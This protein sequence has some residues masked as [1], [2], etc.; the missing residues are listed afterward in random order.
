MSSM[1]FEAQRDLNSR[2]IY[3]RIRERGTQHPELLS[4]EKDQSENQRDY[5]YKVI[6]LILNE[7]DPD[8]FHSL[9]KEDLREDL[10]EQCLYNI[11]RCE[12]DLR[13]QFDYA[14][15]EAIE[16]AQVIAAQT[17]F[18]VEG[19]A[20]LS[21]GAHSLPPIPDDFLEYS[22]EEKMEYQRKARERRYLRVVVIMFL[23]LFDKEMDD[24]YKYQEKT[25]DS[26]SPETN[27]VREQIS[28]AANALPKDPTY[29]RDKLRFLLNLVWDENANSQKTKPLNPTHQEE[30]LVEIMEGN[31]LEG[32]SILVQWIRMVNTVE[33]IDKK[34]LFN[35]VLEIADHVSDSV[36]FGHESV[37]AWRLIPAMSGEEL[38]PETL[39]ELQ[40]AYFIPVGAIGSAVLRSEVSDV[41][42][43]DQVD[44]QT[45]LARSIELN[46]GLPAVLA[47]L[48]FYGSLDTHYDRTTRQ[49]VDTY[50]PDIPSNYFMHVL[51][52]DLELTQGKYLNLLLIS[53]LGVRL[54]DDNKD[55]LSDRSAKVANFYNSSPQTQAQ[56]LKEAGL[57]ELGF[58]D[59]QTIRETAQ[60]L[61][62]IALSKKLSDQL[63][64]S[65][66]EAADPYTMQLYGALGN[67][68]DTLISEINAE[69]TLSLETTEERRFFAAF[70]RRHMYILHAAL[71][72]GLFPD[73][74]WQQK[75]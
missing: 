48:Q 47:L 39:G 54:A 32:F 46:G 16:I 4:P 53:L 33:G 49:F 55:M 7:M 42:D 36:S 18:F 30:L 29:Y 73:E 74:E 63:V 56:T 58:S 19:P 61:Q 52:H 5:L 15:A 75:K 41:P 43:T 6:D 66:R 68:T 28:D 57:A 60:D 12:L 59:N 9:S 37:L 67:L 31:K 11:R 65:Q 17:T 40:E 3:K 64:S 21:D 71:V 20:L 26:L 27:Q 62:R 10:Y 8:S 1:I 51:Q 38:D 35:E 34:E 72:S 44:L 50:K 24:F 70:L 23:Y 14:G 2:R 25:S 69:L 13:G 45:R 22:P